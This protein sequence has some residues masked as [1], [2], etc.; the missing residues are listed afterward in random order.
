MNDYLWDSEY[1][2]DLKNSN[3]IIENLLNDIDI[4]Y[5]N[6]NINKIEKNEIEK[7]KI[8][9]KNMKIVLYNDPVF[10][11]L[12]IY[13]IPCFIYNYIF[14]SSLIKTILNNYLLIG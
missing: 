4:L 8:E 11:L 14:L 1:D 6:I 3:N 12:F 2:F 9:K 7:N 10:T 5:D 13:Y